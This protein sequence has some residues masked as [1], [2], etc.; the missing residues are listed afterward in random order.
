MSVTTCYTLIV[1]NNT[2][3]LSMPGYRLSDFSAP[4]RR[5]FGEYLRTNRYFVKRH[6]LGKWR[7]C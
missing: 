6:N 7:C 2:V 5:V 1:T 4:C 3:K